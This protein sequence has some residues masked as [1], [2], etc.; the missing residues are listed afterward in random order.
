MR[1]LARQ[2]VSRGVSLTATLVALVAAPPLAL[3][4][5]GT[6]CIAPAT[7]TTPTAMVQIY[8]GA[9][10]SLEPI[11]GVEVSVFGHPKEPLVVAQ[12]DENGYVYLPGLSP[13]DYRLAARL[14]GFP[15][16]DGH[17][18]IVDGA[19]MT[20]QLLAVRLEAGDCPSACSLAHPGGP[21]GRP[22]DCL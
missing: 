14:M 8:T 22:P 7:F 11:P 12:T 1:D 15:F 13:G 17:L 5:G 6:D 21:R 3:R 16:F 2:T 20:P 19:K 18:R 9:L 4:G 10:D